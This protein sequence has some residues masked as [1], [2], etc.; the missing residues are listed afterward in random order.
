MGNSLKRDSAE[1]GN[2]RKAVDDI[3]SD[4]STPLSDKFKLTGRVLVKN[5]HTWRWIN[6]GLS[7]LS[8][9]GKVCIKGVVTS[10]LWFCVDHSGRI[11]QISCT[12]PIPDEVN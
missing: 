2:K 9:D 1:P 4:E 11:S 7:K 8:E 3:N 5:C 10:K 12:D 6:D